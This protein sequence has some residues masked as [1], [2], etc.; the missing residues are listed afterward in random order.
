MS[1]WFP[2]KWLRSIKFRGWGYHFR[3]RDGYIQNIYIVYVPLTIIYERY[4]L[5]IY[6]L[7]MTYMKR[8]TISVPDE[9]YE[10]LVKDSNKYCRSLNGSII[11]FLKLYIERIISKGTLRNEK[12]NN[13]I[14]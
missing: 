14:K 11:Y 12:E 1:Y 9:L 6:N 7:Y 5:L 8:L 13:N 10:E 4:I 2:V 3:K